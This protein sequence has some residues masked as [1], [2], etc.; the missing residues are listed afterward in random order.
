[1]AG[2]GNP[3]GSAPNANL[4]QAP[5]TGG[6]PSVSDPSVRLAALEQENQRLQQN[7]RNLESMAGRQTEELGRLRQY[8]SASQA[9]PVQSGNAPPAQEWDV[10]AKMNQITQRLDLLQYRQ[11]TPDW[12]K[13]HDEVT[14]RINDPSRQPELVKFYPDGTVDLFSTYQ[15]AK[16]QVENERLRA[17]M[18][19]L[20]NGGSS[21]VPGDSIGGGIAPLGGSAAPSNAAAAL[22]GG[23]G[24]RPQRQLTLDDLKGMRAEE[25]IAAFPDQVS[26]SDPPVMR[27]PRK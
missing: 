9:Q 27:K 11:V 12:D 17:E 3:N 22:S 7:Y 2:E 13:Y 23:N 6:A 4:G 5:A 19:A 20:R 14:K 26:Q 18:A 10:D 24:Q 1:M 8:Y 15:Y 21:Q 25:I 16:V